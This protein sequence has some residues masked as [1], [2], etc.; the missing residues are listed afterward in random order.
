MH[1]TIITSLQPDDLRPDFFCCYIGEFNIIIRICSRT[2]PLH[3]PYFLYICPLPLLTPEACSAERER[4]R[5]L[6]KFCVAD[7]KKFG[8]RARSLCWTWIRLPLFTPYFL[9]SDCGTSWTPTIWWSGCCT[10][11]P[12][13]LSPPCSSTTRTAST[14]RRGRWLCSWPGST[15][16]CFFKGILHSTKLNI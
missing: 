14:W 1:S 3:K 11:P 8:E 2:F 15:V 16:S 10:C 5:V 6:A 9:C 4:S 7:K 12:P 13:S